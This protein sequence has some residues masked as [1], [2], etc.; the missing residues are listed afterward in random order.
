M[1][2]RN[3]KK[4]VNIRVFQETRDRLKI[5]AVREHKTI[6][7]LTDDISRDKPTFIEFYKKGEKNSFLKNNLTK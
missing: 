3:L 5:R 1:K 2:K 6:M 7:Q 4:T